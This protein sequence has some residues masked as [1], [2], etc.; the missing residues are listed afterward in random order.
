[1]TGQP[2][3]LSDTNAGA[4][5]EFKGH[6]RSAATAACKAPWKIAWLILVLALPTSFLCAA[7]ERLGSPEMR[8]RL[9]AAMTVEHLLRSIAEGPAGVAETVSA[10]EASMDPA[11]RAGTGSKTSRRRVK[12]AD[13]HY[14]DYR[15]AFG[16]P[17]AVV[18]L[19][20]SPCVAPARAA[21]LIGAQPGPVLYD[22]RGADRGR[23]YRVIR[24]GVRIH[25]FTNPLTYECVDSIEMYVLPALAER[26]ARKA[27]MSM[28][29]LLAWARQGREG[30]ARIE[31]ALY[32]LFPDMEPWPGH[33]FRSRGKAWLSSGELLGSATID[34]S[35][36]RITIRPDPEQ[37]AEAWKYVDAMGGEG[38][39]MRDAHLV[40][41]GKTYGIQ[42]NG[43]DLSVETTPRTYDCI[44]YITITPEWKTKV[45]PVDAPTG[46]GR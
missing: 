24:D 7:S 2:A 16:G 23:I 32:H 30:V 33:E 45:M 28:D 41:R 25:I 3:R 1:M 4:L 39:V 15:N 6:G 18:G 37:C 26:A 35:A 9:L 8:D 5:C 11:E 21:A 31:A 19:A 34:K 38:T 20:R 17:G 43:F 29:D 10:I 12:L 44:T 27:G 13:G 40:D 46:A 42:E 36:G 14:V 22:G